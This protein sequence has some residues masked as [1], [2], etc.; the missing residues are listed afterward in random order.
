MIKTASYSENFAAAVE[1]NV[2]RTSSGIKL[3]DF[4]SEICD[5]IIAACD[6]ARS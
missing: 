2:A 6:I 3:D 1:G 5:L 4:T